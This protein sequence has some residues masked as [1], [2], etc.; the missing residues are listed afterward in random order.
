MPKDNAALA[1]EPLPS[2][3]SAYLRT[4][5]EVIDLSDVT[6]RRERLQAYAEATRPV[7]VYRF[8]LPEGATVRALGSHHELRDARA[9]LELIVGLTGGSI[10]TFHGG[11][12]ARIPTVLAARFE[13]MAG[14]LVAAYLVSLDLGDLDAL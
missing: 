2:L 6:L 7:F 12:A 9:Q 8:Q 11:L 5:G 1:V 10:G 14:P 3:E 13:T 4:A